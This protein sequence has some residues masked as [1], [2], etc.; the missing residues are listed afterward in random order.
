MFSHVSRFGLISIDFYDS[1]DLI[2]L[3]IYSV[4]DHLL[5]GWPFRVTRAGDGGG[6]EAAVELEGSQLNQFLEVKTSV[7]CVNY[8][9]SLFRIAT[10]MIVAH[11]MVRLLLEHWGMIWH[12]INGI[13]W[14]G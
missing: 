2:F 5:T 10:R 11:G 13:L 8:N 7:F 12:I 4:L 1:I 3:G 6:S 9:A 14:N